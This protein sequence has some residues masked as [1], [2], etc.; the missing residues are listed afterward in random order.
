MPHR[1]ILGILNNIHNRSINSATPNGPEKHSRILEDEKILKK[2]HVHWIVYLPTLIAGGICVSL[3]MIA[4]IYSYSLGTKLNV[5][6]E[7]VVILFLLL[8]AIVFSFLINSLIFSW[9]NFYLLTDHRLI[10]ISLDKNFTYQAEEYFLAR[11]KYIDSRRLGL[12]SMLLNYGEIDIDLDIGN[13]GYDCIMRR[14]PRPTEV[15][16][17]INNLIEK[18]YGN[19]QN[20][21]HGNTH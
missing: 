10:H 21:Q 2:I 19:I 5:T 7:V 18:K 1:Y 8:F 20:N 13:G 16:T 3:F 15:T 12:F 17:L 14:I 9:F 4:L 6:H 11:I